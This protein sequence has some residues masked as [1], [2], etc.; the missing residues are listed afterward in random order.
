MHY[1]GAS[2][3]GEGGAPPSLLFLALGGGGPLYH[4]SQIRAL[5]TDSLCDS[6]LIQS[7]IRNDSAGLGGGLLWGAGPLGFERGGWRD[8]PMGGSLPCSPGR[9]QIHRWSDGKFER[10]LAQPLPA[11]AVRRTY[12]SCQPLNRAHLRQMRYTRGLAKYTA[13]GSGLGHSTRPVESIT[14]QVMGEPD[15]PLQVVFRGRAG[16]PGPQARRRALCQLGAR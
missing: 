5:S 13:A 6:I 1:V 4:T 3:D 10:S 12:G 11:S 16:T 7:L 14:S 8:D 15:R 2:L 9:G